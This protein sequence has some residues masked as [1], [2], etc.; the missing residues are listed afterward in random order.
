MYVDEFPSVLLFVW[1]AVLA[2][3]AVLAGWLAILAARVAKVRK[4]GGG[5]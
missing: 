4:E 3:W 5:R 2:V 1:L